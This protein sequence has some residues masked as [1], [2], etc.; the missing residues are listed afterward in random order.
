MCIPLMRLYAESNLPPFNPVFI[1][2][3]RWFKGSPSDIAQRYAN[4]LKTMFL[5]AFYAV[6]LPWGIALGIVNLILTYWVDKWQLLR[7][8]REPDMIGKEVMD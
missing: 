7:R 5:T 2:F 4:V 6:A 3:L 8:R 1:K